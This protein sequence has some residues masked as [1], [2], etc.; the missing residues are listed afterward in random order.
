MLIVNFIFRYQLISFVFS[1]KMN[2]MEHSLIPWHVH[3][4]FITI[5]TTKQ[6]SEIKS[7]LTIRPDALENIWP[8]LNNDES[9]IMCRVE[10]WSV[11]KWYSFIEIIIWLIGTYWQACTCRS[12][13]IASRLRSFFYLIL[14]IHLSIYNCC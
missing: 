13:F 4:D 9:K 11:K 12:K 14:N 5:T 10:I 6:H 8:S 2:N 7:C 3:L 1:K